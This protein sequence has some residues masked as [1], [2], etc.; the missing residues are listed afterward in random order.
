[1]N[2][3]LIMMTHLLEASQYNLSYLAHSEE[4]CMVAKCI[5]NTFEIKPAWI[6]IHLF[7]IWI[8]KALSSDSVIFWNF[9]E[10]QDYFRIPVVLGENLQDL[11]AS[12]VKYLLDYYL[13]S[14]LSHVQFNTP[15]STLSPLKYKLWKEG[16]LSILPV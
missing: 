2:P 14:L 12:T 13:L 3:G 9:L 15:P 1:M 6:C 8:L 4:N 11:K 7:Q 10:E 16:L 5:Q